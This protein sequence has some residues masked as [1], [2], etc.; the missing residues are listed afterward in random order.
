MRNHEIKI[1]SL[2]DPFAF[3][4]KSPAGNP[5]H[6]CHLQY[7]ILFVL[8]YS[9]LSFSCS[10]HT[11]TGYNLDHNCRV[12]FVL[13]ALIQ[14]CLSLCFC[15]S[16]DTRNCLSFCLSICVCLVFVRLTSFVTPSACLSQGV[17]AL[18]SLIGYFIWILISRYFMQ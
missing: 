5:N 1:K 17:S 12:L 18:I 11:Y 10:L 6:H 2:S 9:V 16:P 15:L 7:S 13:V 14:F 3:G 8:F 4:H